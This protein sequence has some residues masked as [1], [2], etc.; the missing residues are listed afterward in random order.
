VP[1]GRRYMA[2][3][4]PVPQGTSDPSGAPRRPENN[5]IDG[6]ARGAKETATEGGQGA[7]LCWCGAMSVNVS[8]VV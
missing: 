3:P 1:A 7:R 2:I 8:G 4:V 5:A 6:E